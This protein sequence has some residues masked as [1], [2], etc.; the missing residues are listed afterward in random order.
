MQEW[1]RKVNEII[2]DEMEDFYEQFYDSEV[3]SVGS[4][5]IGLEPCPLC[6][7]S[8]CCRVTD[9]GVR[10]FSC[11]WKGGHVKAYKEYASNILK[12][13]ETFT[14]DKLAKW[15]NVPIPENSEKDSEEKKEEYIRQQ[16]RRIAREFYHE[17]LLNCNDKYVYKGQN[18]TPYAYLANIRKRKEKSIT[19]FKIGFSLNYLSLYQKL[20]A[21]GFKE[22]EIKEAKV[23]APEGMFVY[24]YENPVS[25]EILRLNTKNP[26][27]VKDQK[28]V[29]WEGY[30]TGNKI[31]YYAPGFSFNRNIIVVEGENDAQA[32]YEA[33]GANVAAIGG[34][35]KPEYLK[36]FERAKGKI[37]ACFDN[38]DVGAKY[39]AMLNAQLPEKPIYS[40]SYPT[41]YKDPDEYLVDCNDPSAALKDML[42]NAEPLTTEDYKIKRVASMTWQA[43]NRYRKME[44]KLT[45]RDKSK[46]LIGNAV[47]S[48]GGKIKDREDQVAILK[49]KAAFKPMAF[50][51][52]DEIEKYFSE[53][54][55]IKS[56]EE[57]ANIIPFALNKDFIISSLAQ[58]FNSSNNPDDMIVSIKQKLRGVEKADDIIDSILKEANDMQNRNNT[59]ISAYPKIKICQY[60]NIKNNDAYFYFTN[61][62]Y[63]GDVVRKLPYLLRND[64]QLIR[65]DLYKRKDEQCLLLVD[66]KYELPA[67]QPVALA[68]STLG[69][70]WVEK[71]INDE[72]PAEELEPKV[73]VKRI[74][75]YIRRF[76]YTQ[77]DNV[78]KIISLYAYLTYYY[79]ALGEVPYL[80]FNGE[81]GSGKSILDTAMSIFC[82]NAKMG[83]S[84]SEASLFR[85]TSI[86]GG[87]IILDEI[88]NLTSRKA[89]NES[90]LASILKGGYTR[91]AGIFRVDEDGVV[92]QY[93]AFGPK[94]ISNISGLEDIVLD[95]CIQIS[96]YRLKVTNETRMEDVRYFKAEHQDEI[97]EITSKCCLSAL[98]HFQKLF[99]IFR[100]GVFEASSARL[101]QIL[102]TMLAV[103]RLVDGDKEL[104]GGAVGEYETALKE[105]YDKS[106]IDMKRSIEENTPEGI[107]KKI[108]PQIAKELSG[109]VP[110]NEI[111]L[112]DTTLHR[113]DEP[114]EYSLEEGWF[115]VNALHFKVFLEEYMIGDTIFARYVPRYVLAAYRVDSKDIRRKIVKINDEEL[116][117]EFRGN[118]RPKVQVFKFYF[119]DFLDDTFLTENNEETPDDTSNEEIDVF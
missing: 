109:Q 85:L 49:C 27:R 5:T 36:I 89:A 19:D 40:L 77:D 35:V 119:K 100:G 18:I 1:Y 29:V 47:L 99:K 118:I 15:A 101:S 62:K 46:Q 21:E 103:A 11:D 70:E 68:S 43:E 56:P 38:D 12:D 95:R 94:I 117:R 81:K 75:D 74:E 37:F 80:Y 110:A 86:E 31:L 45:H 64:K 51:I 92:R 66:N 106:I 20:I 23:W 102:T 10:C 63:D 54:L 58:K 39:T 8:G 78:Y 50:F 44:F 115:K 22:A 24:F 90:L 69:Q 52:S 34:N 76:Y 72:I 13:S 55:D 42:K 104:E 93:D 88:E 57:L 83:V 16:I 33:D 116:A 17:Q 30:S 2:A 60:F 113:Y 14:M 67:E 84:M 4:G 26:F 111:E 9:V 59:N 7:H 71:W 96:T 6:G 108:L 41:S 65:L 25:G 53:D 82:F 105:Y 112:T 97:N 3:R 32:I 61:V 98:T 73:L 107:I 79:E 28:G 91:E 87:T 48:V 114:I